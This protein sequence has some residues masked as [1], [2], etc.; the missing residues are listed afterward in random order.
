MTEQTEISEETEKE[1]H[2]FVLRLFRS[3]H[4]SRILSVHFASNHNHH[5]KS[6]N[7]EGES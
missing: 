2:V 4:L 7:S 6:K 5:F 3:F 1:S